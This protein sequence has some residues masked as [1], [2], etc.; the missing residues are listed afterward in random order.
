MSLKS[1]PATSQ[2]PMVGDYQSLSFAG[3]TAH[4]VFALANPR[5]SGKFDEAMYSP[6]SG[7]TDGIAIYPAGQDKPVPN[8]HSDHPRLTTPVKDNDDED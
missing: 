3:G 1:L 8:A 2:G 6:V 4:P 5:S 7:L